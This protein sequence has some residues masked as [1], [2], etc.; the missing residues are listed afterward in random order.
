MPG[1]KTLWMLGVP[2]GVDDIRP[3]GGN[4]YDLVVVV[5]ASFC[6]SKKSRVDWV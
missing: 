6:G 3:A 4:T 5:V 2:L 1:L